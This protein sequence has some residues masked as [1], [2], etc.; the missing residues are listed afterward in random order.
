MKQKEINETEIFP[1]RVNSNEQV[2]LR[3]GIKNN[4]DFSSV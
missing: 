3:L 4:E 2:E 1:E